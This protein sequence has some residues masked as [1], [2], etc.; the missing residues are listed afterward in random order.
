M[1][2]SSI[3]SLWMMD[4]AHGIYNPWDIMDGLLLMIHNLGLLWMG[5]SYIISI[6]SFQIWVVLSIISCTQWSYW[7]WSHNIL[8]GALK[9]IFFVYYNM[10]VVS[11]THL[12]HLGDYLQGWGYHV[13][14]SW[15]YCSLICWAQWAS[16]MFMFIFS[17]RLM[18]TFVSVI[19]W[20]SNHQH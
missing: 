12:D 15:A 3:V 9:I 7:H 16:F 6:I 20:W 8:D 1:I 11:Y 19:L 2:T 4:H 18:V 5:A 17:L 13:S 14:F 10:N